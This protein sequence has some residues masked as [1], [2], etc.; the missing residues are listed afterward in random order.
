M[1]MQVKSVLR[2]LTGSFGRALLLVLSVVFAVSCSD[3]DKKA[4]EVHDATAVAGTYVGS[5]TTGGLPFGALNL[6]ITATKAD[7]IMINT[8]IDLSAATE[9]P[10]F[11]LPVVCPAKVTFENNLYVVAGSVIVSVPMPGSTD[12][13]PLPVQI[14]GTITSGAVKTATLTITP[15]IPNMPMEFEYIGV[16]SN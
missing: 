3:D 8:T 6:T 1:K 11:A 16:K 13:T 14:G 7:S 2:S 12:A 9:I 5:L 4:E 15:A 10:G